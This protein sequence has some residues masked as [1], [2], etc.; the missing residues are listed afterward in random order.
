[1]EFFLENVL[2]RLRAG[3]KMYVLLFL[4]MAIGSLVLSISLNLMFTGEKQRREYEKQNMG[5]KIAITGTMNVQSA[6]FP[7]GAD[8]YEEL[9]RRYDGKLSFALSNT[10]VNDLF[11]EKCGR[12]ETVRE[13]CM[14]DALVEEVFGQTAGQIDREHTVFVGDDAYEVLV[15]AG[16]EGETTRHYI[17]EELYIADDQLFV[18]GEPAFEVKPVS[19]I[20]K[21]QVQEIAEVWTEGTY[22]VSWAV[23][24]P[25]SHAAQIEAQAGFR[26]WRGSKCSGCSA[27]YLRMVP[28]IARR[29][30]ESML[31]LQTA[32]LAACLNCSSGI[33]TASGIFPPYW[34]T[35]FTNSCGTEEDPCRT[36]GKP[37]SLLMHSS[38][39]SKRSGGGTR[40]PSAFLVH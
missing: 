18:N 25:F 5:R 20:N 36:I 6:K 7:V 3:R 33:P 29:I 4:E 27:K 37:G 10:A 40:M 22:P 30:S 21:N 19:E 38:R 12:I 26:Y 23:I 32:S 28:V 8:T 16:Q 14:D 9:Q 35:I 2:R 31:I 15:Q 39:T 24:F 11:L 17:I 34:L 1:M 13:Y